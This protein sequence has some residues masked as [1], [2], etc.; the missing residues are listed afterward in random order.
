M[1]AT[2][3]SSPGR[4]SNSPGHKSKKAGK[5]AMT[6][7]KK[8]S[9]RWSAEDV[10]DLLEKRLGQM[11]Y[12]EI[13]TRIGRTE[14]SCRLKIHTEKKK[15]EKEAA[16]TESRMQANAAQAAA[17]YNTQPVQPRQLLPKPEA[18]PGLD[19]LAEAAMNAHVA[20]MNPFLAVVMRN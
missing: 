14:I 19:M 18:H 9:K 15:Q 10:K 20:A 7:N 16:A 5:T 6:E 4:K 12:H 2:K 11:P 8:S 13:A 3:R 17:H 1:G